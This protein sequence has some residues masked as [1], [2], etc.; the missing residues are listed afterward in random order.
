MSCFG[1]S[2]SSPQYVTS[3]SLMLP[4][5]VCIMNLPIFSI[6]SKYGFIILSVSGSSTGMLIT[7]FGDWSLNTFFISF[8]TIIAASRCA[9]DVEAAMCGVKTTLSNSKRRLSFGGSFS[10]T[11][12]PAPL[13]LPVESAW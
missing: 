7:F 1:N 3:I 5:A 12:S 2:E 4:L 8:A 9:S 13:I 10:N 6:S 11:S